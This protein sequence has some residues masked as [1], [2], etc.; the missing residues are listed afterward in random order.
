MSPRSFLS[1]FLNSDRIIWRKC[2]DVSNFRPI[3]D[4]K[5]KLEIKSENHNSE[6]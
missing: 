5:K 2:E 4:W 1:F 6:K 3:L